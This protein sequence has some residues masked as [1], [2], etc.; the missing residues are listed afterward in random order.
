MLYR[1]KTYSVLPQYI[2]ERDRREEGVE[3]EKKQSDKMKEKE[4]K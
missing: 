4:G 3:A 2:R 1:L